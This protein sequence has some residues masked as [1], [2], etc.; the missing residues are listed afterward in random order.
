MPL[1]NLRTDLT[2][3]RYGNDRPGGGN[4]GQP[5]MQFPID[6]PNAPAD[7]RAYYE[8]N[9]NSLD[10]PVRGGAIT[11]L[12]TGGFGVL[13]STLDRERIQ[14][15]F[16]DVPRGTAFIQ[17]QVGLQAS[18][19]RLQ[20]ANSLAFAGP[21]LN[22]AV[23]PVTN[24]YNPLNTLAQ[25]QVQGTGTHFNRH[26]VAPNIFQA[27]QQTYAYIVGNPENNTESTNR[28]AILRALKLI[29]STNFLTNPDE[30]NSGG[31][32]PT[33]V[34]RLGISTIQNQLFNYAGG[35]G[36]VYGIGFTRIFRY[37]DTNVTKLSETVPDKQFS[38]GGKLAVSYSSIAFTYKQIAEQTT[39]QDGTLPTQPTI[40]DF[41]NQLPGN[42]PKT[43]Y[44][45][46]NRASKFDGTGGLGL[47]NPGG[48]L[49]NPDPLKAK[50]GGTDLLN[51]LNPFYYNAAEQD[52][53]TAGGDETKDIIKFTFE[54]MSN[55]N[56]DFAVALMFRALLDG[57]IADN[58]QGEYSTYK[59]LG[60][61]ETFRTYQGFD[62][63]IGF[64]FKMFPQSRTEVKPL[65]TKLNT[66]ISQ[67][68]PDYS[69]QSN[70]LRGSVV[71]LTIG[72]YIYRMPGF[73]ES[74]NVTIDNST[75][76]WEIK[77]YKNE[78]DVAQLPHV[79][80]VNC[81]FRPIMDILPARVTEQRQSVALIGNVK[82]NN[83]LNR[84]PVVTAQ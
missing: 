1:L 27:P 53:W 82:N 51:N 74:V 11:Q 42:I 50:Q 45:V 10:F 81:S 22:N 64:S 70:L 65:Y 28:L 66:L 44:K 29:G 17:K 2:S 56:P 75:T 49:T 15:F 5:Y 18:N 71:R 7:L 39:R 26:G 57:V 36:S 58:N 13:S 23:L 21:A 9:R 54:C 60:R 16:K 33:L 25:V 19:P 76:P 40:Q 55:D 77:L 20:V 24:V 31:I 4:S 83:F 41:R 43:D 61:G 63:S 84:F 46:Y 79:V 48:P 72:D 78:D 52:P 8:A 68:Y 32:N 6:T 38:A 47:G 37:V 12:V 34:D 3:L 59:Y 67:V 69:P 30:V 35:P 14:K 73:L 80:T 62:R